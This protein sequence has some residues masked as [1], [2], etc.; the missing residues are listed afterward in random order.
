MPKTLTKSTTLEV[1]DKAPDFE[2]QDQYGNKITLGQFKG[3]VLILYFYPKD[4]T[5]GCTK[6]A[7]SLRDRYSSFKK[8][9]VVVL[10]ISK[11][12]SNSHLKFIEKYELPFN[13][14]PDINK[15]IHRAYGVWVEKTMYGRTT[16]GTQRTTFIIG[17]NQKI[18]HIFTRVDCENHAE[19][20]LDKLEELD[21]KR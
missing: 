10:G 11:D 16:M 4:N 18:K 12:S 3:K 20:I 6:E 7:C 14:I 5:P 21:I 9:N 15:S 1:G 17:P 2:A 8:K 19:E 13:L